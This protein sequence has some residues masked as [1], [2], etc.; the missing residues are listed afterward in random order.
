MGEQYAKQQ[1]RYFSTLETAQTDAIRINTEAFETPRVKCIR[2]VA[3]EPSLKRRAHPQIL[4]QIKC[5][6]LNQAYKCMVN[7]NLGQIF[8]CHD[9]SRQRRSFCT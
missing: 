2:V 6:T 5:H 4:L 7:R 3:S 8:L 1:A 9:P